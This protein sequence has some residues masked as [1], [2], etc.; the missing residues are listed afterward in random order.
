MLRC[1]FFFFFFFVVVVD[2]SLWKPIYSVVVEHGRKKSH[3]IFVE[4]DCSI[5]RN[6]TV[7]VFVGLNALN[8]IEHRCAKHIANG[9]DQWEWATTI[10]SKKIVAKSN[11]NSTPMSF[12]YEDSAYIHIFCIKRNKIAINFS[13]ACYY[14]HI[15]PGFLL[16]FVDI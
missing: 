16:H 11:N 3:G 15:R 5:I 10:A 8:N 4:F 1:Y 7:D 2:Y 14:T 6:S 12:R 9:W 13:N